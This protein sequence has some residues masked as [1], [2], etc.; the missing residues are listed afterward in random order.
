MTDT[1][2]LMWL[3]VLV[4]LTAVVVGLDVSVFVKGAMV[5]FSI[6]IA[7]WIGEASFK[8]RLREHAKQLDR[9]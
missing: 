7:S 8:A 5:G 4:V 9:R 1:A 3:Y 2:W 6:M